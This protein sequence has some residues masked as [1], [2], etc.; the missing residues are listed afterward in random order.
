MKRKRLTSRTINE[1]N[2]SGVIFTFDQ[3][4]EY[5]LS[6]KKAEG[7]RKPTITSYHEHFNFFKNW[8]KK[9]HSEI[10]NVNHL[11]V[12]IIREYVNYL[13]NEHFNFK[14]KEYGLSVQTTN[15]RLRFLKTF[16]NFLFKEELANTNP[17]EQVK[18]IKEDER[19][20]QPLSET[21]IQKLLNVPNTSQYPQF[22][23]KCIMYL[24]YDTGLRIKEAISLSVDDLDLN[25]RRIIL[26]A[27]NAKGR[28]SRII[29]LSGLVIKMLIELISENQS[30]FENRKLFLNWYGEP[31]AE[32][33]F[34]RNLKR[35]V[36]KAGISKPFTCH[37]FR[38][39]SITE[40]LAS[41][42][43][44][45]AV[46]SIVGHS[47]ISTTKKYVHFDEQTI[48]NQHELYSPLVKVK[49]KGKLR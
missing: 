17:P 19:I 23:D 31:M 11:T 7:L 14:T 40:M 43:S 1:Y 22:R 27:A 34:R 20:F 30:H 6:S 15:A 10:V 47:E 4:Y 9:S 26:P 13:K 44:L 8:L 3:A 21:E 29:P 42:A 45:F 2:S 33:T 16:Y 46:Q 41:G 12:Q 28:K 32:D 35:Y 48:K 25:G 36:K 24:L 18:F 37:D 39:Q 38:R 49:R 5:F